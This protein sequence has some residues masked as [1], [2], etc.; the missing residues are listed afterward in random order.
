[1]EML[2]RAFKVSV[3]LNRYSSLKRR[4]QILLLINNGTPIQKTGNLRIKMRWSIA[5]LIF[6]QLLIVDKGGNNEPTLHFGIAG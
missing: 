1:M 6:L 3:V 5:Y 4:F 2:R